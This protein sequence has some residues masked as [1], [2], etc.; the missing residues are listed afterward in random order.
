MKKFFSCVKLFLASLLILSCNSEQIEALTEK[1]TAIESGDVKTIK[2][3]ILNIQSS[4]INL[5]TTSIEVKGYI[6]D[7]QEEQK[8]LQDADKQLSDRLNNLKGEMESQQSAFESDILDRLT[9]FKGQI[10]TQI[11]AL[12]NN[13]LSLQEKD[14][15]LENRITA[16][17][18]YVNSE[19]QSTKDWVSTTYV[20]LEEYRKT[21]GIVGGIQAQIDLISNQLTNIQGINNI[22]TKTDI[23]NA[24]ASIDSQWKEQFKELSDETASNLSQATDKITKAYTKAISDALLQS[25]SSL[26]SWVNERLT[27]YYT[28]AQVEV[29]LMELRN[30]YDE[31]LNVQ[32]SYLEGLISSL[33]SSLMTKINSNSALINGLQSQSTSLSNDLVAITEQISRNSTAISDNAQEISENAKAIS[34]NA[35]DIAACNELAQANKD[36]IQQNEA[37]ITQNAQAISELKGKVS[38]AESAIAENAADIA[39]NAK[40]IAANAAL[41]AANATAISNNAEAISDNASD[42]IRLG[43]KLE[44]AKTEITTAYRKAISDAITTL[45]GKLSGQIASEVSTINTRITEE[46]TAVNTT[47]DALA[48]RVGK[49]ESDIKSIKTSIYNMQIEISD[50]QEQIADILSRIQSISYVPK[51][52]D[53]SAVMYYTANGTITPGT[54]TFDFELFPSSTA[55]ALAE[56]W[57][58]ALSMK[59]VYTQTKSAA[60]FVN[61]PITSVSAEDGI[62]TLT[63]SGANM[64][65]AFFLGQ[66]SASA[67]LYISDGHNERASEYIK[68]TPWTTDIISFQD[69]NFK[70][71][72]LENFDTNGDGEISYDEG[73]AITTINISNYSPSI[74]NLSGI[75]YFSNLTTLDC[76]Y[77]KI[78]SLNLSNNSALVDLNVSHNTLTYLN[79]SGL[80][81]LTSIDVSSNKLSSLGVSSA[82][83]LSS[84][85]CSNNQIGELV[86]S[87]NKA[88][89]YLQCSGNK[90]G[91]LDLTNQ[92]ALTELYCRSNKLTLLKAN[93]CTLL[94]ILDCSDNSLKSLNLSDNLAIETLYCSS[95]SLTDLRIGAN[96]AIASLDCS[97]NSLTSLNLLSCTNIENLDCSSNSLES[98]DVS[99]LGR[100]F[101]LNCASNTI[102][103]LDV[104]M[105]TGLSVLNCTSDKLLKLWLKDTE[106][107]LSLSIT[108][109][110]NTNIF[111]NN[112]GIYIPDAKLKSYLVTNFDE[113]GDGEIS[114]V[115]A[116]F[117]I[118]INCSGKSISDLT[119]VEAFTNLSYLNCSNNSLTKLDLHTLTKLETLLC[120]SNKLSDI[121]LDNCASLR[122]IYLFDSSTNIFSVNAEQVAWINIKNYTQA[123]SLKFA[124]D[125]IKYRICVQ[126]SPNLTSVDLSNNVCRDIVV[127]ENS[128]MTSVKLPASLVNYYGYSCAL[129][130]IDLSNCPNL[131]YLQIYSNNL[132]SLDVSHNPELIEI[133]GWNNQLTS[134]DISSNP[135]MNILRIANN[136]LTSINLSSNTLI[137]G[138]DLNSN[139]L[140]SINVRTLSKLKDLYIQNN[141]A[142][143]DI[144]VTN[145]PLLAN[146]NA[147]GTKITSL[148]VS[149]NTALNSL[150]VSSTSI[151]YLTLSG[152]MTL[153]NTVVSG[154]RTLDLSGFTLNISGTNLIIPIGT[155][156]KTANYSGIACYYSNKNLIISLTATAAQY[157]TS[158]TTAN[159]NNNDDGMKNMET[160]KAVGI[161]KFPAFQWCNNLGTGWYLPARNEMKAIYEHRTAIDAT[162]KAIGATQLGTKEYWTSTD[163]LGQG[164]F[165][166][167]FATGVISNSGKFK[168]NTYNVRAVHV[169]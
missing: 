147:S 12:N 138:I 95:N 81:A 64:S 96:K 160:I 25:E 140:A 137:T 34:S 103:S 125:V 161:S 163:D 116:D 15:N 66:I 127:N 131:R 93:K 65:E 78:S 11:D 39:E 43:Q 30:Y 5:Q 57:Q 54:V 36:L 74:T 50:I 16:L 6:S 159:A 155:Y 99:T 7:L 27:A 122:T 72:L 42:I 145:N 9:S 69:T 151:T 117:I 45:D 47:I 167:N 84:L 149:K 124:M 8:R 59:A 154:T 75:E 121:N 51:Y 120:Y 166:L 164:A 141:T 29:K 33:E 112:G 22:A 87:N 19:I 135:K 144:N 97:K 67:R 70:A 102:S 98:L 76:S 2:E 10:G 46:I 101:S 146:L 28:A 44:E 73:K 60:D 85:V 56:V 129:K 153:R 109:H 38:N 108:K 86:L 18:T 94:T 156:V 162:L 79:T 61:L 114:P 128:A 55:S 107:Q 158:A 133:Q 143:T 83:N 115:E 91:K 142:I 165:T 40:D 31:Q 113:D 48:V 136:K 134:L 104:S 148:D 80:V 139:N 111:F 41:I 130:S 32:R 1:V 23:D 68:I 119:G 71:Y 77:N 106:Q 126:Q 100:L 17:Q 123:T 37:A 62:L 24:I 132:T 13:I 20:T 14:K 90:L 92:T 58:T 3:Q 82:K 53:G 4:I 88:L 105:L 63:V 52:S 21:A 89:T 26:K 49:C 169:F 157:R 150:D 152:N 35:S 110:G 168:T 118:S